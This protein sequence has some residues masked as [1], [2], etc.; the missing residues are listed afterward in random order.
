MVEAV[1]RDS[2]DTLPSCVYL[3]GEYGVSD[4]YVSVPATLGRA[5]VLRIDELPLD[6]TELA[7]LRS[8]AATIA[9]SLDALGLRG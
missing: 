4:L 8:S 3:D 5:G 7:A 1:L 6:E 2:G 9:E